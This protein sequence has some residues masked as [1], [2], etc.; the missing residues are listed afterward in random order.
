MLSDVY[1]FQILIVLFTKNHYVKNNNSYT[2]SDNVIK[3]MRF[4][5]NTIVLWKCFLLECKSNGN[6]IVQCMDLKNLEKYKAKE[7]KTVQ[8][9]CNTFVVQDI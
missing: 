7:T 5:Y 4:Q 1:S 3:D 8:V 6:N 9:Q 2:H